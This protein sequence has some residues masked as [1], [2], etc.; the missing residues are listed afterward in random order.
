MSKPVTICS[1]CGKTGVTKG[2]IWP[3][4][5]LKFLPSN[6]STHVQF[7]EYYRAN[8][9]IDA[10]IKRPV[11]RQRQGRGG[12]RKLRNTC[13]ECNNHRMSIV[14]NK[15]K[16]ILVKLFE[17]QY[18]ILDRSSQKEISDLICLIAL[19]AEFLN[20]NSMVASDSDRRDFMEYGISNRNWQVRIGRYGGNYVYDKYYQRSYGIFLDNIHN[21][22]EEENY[23]TQV[24]TFVWGKLICQVINSSSEKL[25]SEFY[26]IKPYLHPIWPIRV[27][28]FHS[29]IM[30]VV[31]EKATYELGEVLIKMHINK[32][33][34][35]I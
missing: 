11:F 33:K 13:K 10:E 26:A 2:H 27:D 1:F 12:T 14:E 16:E 20:T 7:S 32:I 31:S 18:P 22:I 35:K 9:P 5:F 4:W 8:V 28:N 21:K 29:L 3:E 25:L 23:N 34:Q 17:G 30:P 19:R 6:A 15:P 24:S